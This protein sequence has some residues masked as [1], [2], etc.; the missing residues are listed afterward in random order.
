MNPTTVWLL[1][2]LG[3]ILGSIGIGFAIGCKVMSRK[4]VRMIAGDEDSEA[5]RCSICNQPVR[6][7]PTGLKGRFTHARCERQQRRSDAILNAGIIE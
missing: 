7:V 4:A 1:S 2:Q 6:D 5:Y 3:M